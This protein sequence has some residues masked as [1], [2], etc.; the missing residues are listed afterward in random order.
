MGKKITLGYGFNFNPAFTA[1]SIG[2]G[3]KFF[4]V[5]HDF[6]VEGVI[7]KKIALGASLKLY[8]SSYNNTSTIDL[9][10]LPVPEKF[11]DI[12]HGYKNPEGKYTIK[13]KNYAVY[14][15]FFKDNYIAPWGKYRILGLTL[16]TYETSYDSST[17]YLRFLN[18]NGNYK[19]PPDTFQHGYFG[20]STQNYKYPDL[21]IGGGKSRIFANS[22]VI[23]YGYTL[24]FVGVLLAVLDAP[25]G[26]GRADYLDY[27]KVTSGSRV[28]R[29]NR[30][31]FYF[32]VAYLF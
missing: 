6:F 9:Y 11:N 14:L 24:N 10:R 21:L 22:V 17:M 27:I 13:A 19:A 26:D 30:F 12:R 15:K 5:Q 32:R 31:N 16:N 18:F 20:P 3:D 28:R 8:K 23:D 4:N 2:Y 29:I 25:D 1:Y 7:A